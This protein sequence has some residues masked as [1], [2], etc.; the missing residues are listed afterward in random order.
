M[1]TTRLISTKAPFWTF[2]DWPLATKLLVLLIL[3]GWVAI[4]VILLL[5][6]S[7]LNEL[8]NETSTNTLQ[9]EVH[10]ISQRF[11]E[12]QSI[13]QLNAAQLINEHFVLDA[14]ENDD[15]DALRSS[16]LAAS[17]R[18]EFSYIQVLDKDGQSLGVVQSIDLADASGEL[19]KLDNLG[20]LEIETTRLV[21]T[22]HGWLMTIVKPIKSHSGLV[23]VLTAGRLLDDTTLG[24]LNFE[25]S[26]PRLVLFDGLANVNG[27][28]STE[29]EN[30]SWGQFPV[31]ANLWNQAVAGNVVFGTADIQGETQRV[32]YAPLIVGDHTAAVFS[33]SFS[34]AD[35]ISVRNRLILTE[36]LGGII[37]ALISIT[38]VLI[39]VRRSILQPVSKLVTAAKEIS[40]GNFD[41]TVSGITQRDE[42]G[43]LG[44]AFNNMASKLRQSVE[45]L[46]RHATEIETVSEVSRRLSTILNEGQ[47]VKEVVEQVRSAF[48]YYHAHIYL[49]N[50]AGDELIMAGGTG[51]AGQTMLAHGHKI[52]MGKGLVGRA[53]STNSIV[54]VSDTTSNPDWLPNPLL[55]DTRSEV[56][57]PISIGNEILG[58]L[59]VQHNV[60]GGLTQED[61]ELLKSIANQVAVALLNTRSYRQVQKRAEREAL[62]T[63][64]N[65]KI[66]STSSMES[67]LQVAVRE[68]GRALGTQTS[69]ELS[70]SAQRMENK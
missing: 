60:T 59:D 49:V 17:T 4:N 56:A 48:N 40:A 19:K 20:L 69:V 21:P 66:Q 57:V 70:Q 27:V 64:I 6:V 24:A 1:K 35:T 14:I 50:E 28:A 42:L 52:T 58:V 15:R 25:R 67:A 22:S 62:I 9:E 43:V 47:L 39:M 53:A 34:V 54:L 65:Q 36:I 7:G 18:A 46:R 33:L 55:P 16:L 23:G 51:E 41:I 44:E 13:L 32:A 26:N 37:L 68:L 29:A 3:P 5:T 8:Q 10:I 63:A 12:Q 11:A 31:D 2:R 45:D 38:S 61:A 30:E